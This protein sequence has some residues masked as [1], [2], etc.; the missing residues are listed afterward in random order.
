MPGGQKCDLGAM[1]GGDDYTKGYP[2]V[3]QAV[4]DF[5]GPQNVKVRRSGTLLVGNKTN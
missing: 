4:W 1:F 5:F 2:G 3:Q